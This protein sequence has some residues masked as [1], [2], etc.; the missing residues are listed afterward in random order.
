MA[1]V[2]VCVFYA[3][4]VTWANLINSMIIVPEVMVVKMT[5]LPLLFPREVPEGGW[6][7]RTPQTDRT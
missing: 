3:T 4:V 1:A 2:Y 5:R 7:I 6:A